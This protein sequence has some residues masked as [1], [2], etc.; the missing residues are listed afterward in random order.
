MT[1]IRFNIYNKF[2]NILLG[3]NIPNAFHTKLYGL[4]KP[5]ENTIY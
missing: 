5:I 2:D 3:S 1:L 4:L